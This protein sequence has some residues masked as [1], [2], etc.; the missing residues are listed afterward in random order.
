MRKPRVVVTY[1]EA[2]MGHIVSAKAISEALKR[3]YGDKLDIYDLY[4]AE[5][6]PILEK[7]Q[8]NLVNDVKKSNK[9]PAY[10]S[11]QFFCMNLF[12]W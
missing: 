10:S 7:Y 4:L 1:I 11:F 5:K 12:G 9:N 8:K 2:G 6:S 3:N